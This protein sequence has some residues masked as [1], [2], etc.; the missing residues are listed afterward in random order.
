MLQRLF[1]IAALLALPLN[2]A[3]EDL[4]CLEYPVLN[5]SDGYPADYESYPGIAYERSISRAQIAT[6]VVVGVAFFTIVGVALTNTPSN[7]G[8]HCGHCN[9]K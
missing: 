3:E 7:H 5:A 1:L 8:H 2:A 4:A 6:T 9:S